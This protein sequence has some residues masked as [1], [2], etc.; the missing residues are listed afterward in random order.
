MKPPATANGSAHKPHRTFRLPTEAEWE[1]AARGGLEQKS[2]PWGDAPPQ[3]LPDYST[4]WRNGP[5]PVARYTPNAFGLYD[6]GDN[7]H[8]WCSDWYDP[9]YYSHIAGEK[10]ERP[11]AKF[12]ETATQVL[13]RRLVAPPDQGSPLLCPLQHPPEFQYADYGFRVARKHVAPASPPGCR[14]RVS[15]SHCAPS[16]LPRIIFV[17]PSEF[18]MFRTDL[19][20]DKRILITGGGT[21]LGKGMAARFLELGATVHICGRR[22]GVLEEAAAEL[23]LERPDSRHPLRR[24]QPRRRRSHDRLPFGAKAPLD[25]LVNNAAGNFIARTEELSPG[26]MELRHRHRP[27][28]HSHCTMACG[29]RWLQSSPRNSSQHLRNLRARRLCLCRSFGCLQSRS[30]SPYPQSR[31]RMGKPRHPHERHRF[32]PHPHARRILPRPSA[33]RTRK[34]LRSS[35]TRSTAL[36]PSR[37]SRISQLF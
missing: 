18:L 35:A 26:A 1:L 15:R 24:S 13:P 20:K 34:R 22:E 14:E 4:R 9:N 33:S 32:R 16:R 12:H 7:V 23:E 31:R 30:G 27:H 28:G 6:I 11:R 25:I 21:G 36:A 19:L 5:E 8:E 29:R 3:S 2:F 10:P 37:T 17:P